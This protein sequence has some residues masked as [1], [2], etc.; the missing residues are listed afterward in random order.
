[1]TPLHI[2]LAGPVAL[3]LISPKLE[4]ARP[5]TDGY[6]AP[7][8]SR[9]TL[10]LL[11]RGHRVTIFTLSMNEADF[12]VFHGERLTVNVG[13][14]RKRLRWVDAFRAERHAL[15]HVM[16]PSTCDIIHAH[17][18][19]EF[20]LAALRSGKPTLVTVHD[21][22][23]EVLRY[24]RHPYRLV[25]LGMQWTVLRRAQ[26]VTANSPYISERAT[27]WAGREV[28]VVPNGISI[29]SSC[30]ERGSPPGAVLG[31]L[32][33]GFGRLKNV[34]ALLEAFVTVRTALPN[35]VLRLG[36]PDHGVGERAHQWAME[37][38]LARGVEFL[39]GLSADDVP[40]FMRS[41]DLFVHPS[42]EESFGMVLVEA[43][44]EG[45]PVV[46]GAKSGAVPWVLDHGAAGSLV[47]M[48]SSGAIAMEIVRLLQ[49]PVA[50]RKSAA[51]GFVSI[52]QR[53][54]LERVVDGYEQQYL[55]VLGD[56]GC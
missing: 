21:W 1:M 44:A 6:S 27:R 20:A 12:G 48:G 15:Q 55:R 46:A 51:A 3:Q 23:P 4:G 40:A 43:L 28:P 56:V 52:Q 16:V 22:A 47:D 18:S 50:L 25:R 24:Q 36:G 37:R 14:I 41:L 45:T 53:F 9:L 10:E 31:A 2:G 34:A 54:S 8:I 5:G 17:W 29:P 38:D 30:P 19:Y 13:P 49:D 32:N 39:G 42:L 7:L 11:S 33:V 26:H 35:A